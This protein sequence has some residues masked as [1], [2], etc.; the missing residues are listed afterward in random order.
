MRENVMVKRV[1]S[2]IVCLGLFATSLVAVQASKQ[3]EGASEPKTMSNAPAVLPI[4]RSLAAPAVGVSPRWSP[5]EAA[6]PQRPGSPRTPLIRGAADAKRAW[7]GAEHYGLTLHKVANREDRSLTIELR[8]AQDVVTVGIDAA[9]VVTVSRGGRAVRVRTPGSLARAQQLLAGS[10]AAFAARVMLADR[11]AVSDLKAP[12]MALL[13]A[14]AFVA[15]LVGDID[16]PRR[17]ATRFLEKHRGLY[18]PARMSTCFDAY[19]SES[20]SAWNDM[21]DCVDEANQDSSL[22]NRAY[23]R[24]ACNAIWLLRAESA[25]I[26]YLGCLGPKEIIPE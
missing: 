12:E 26:E 17:L 10:D 22:I 18:R 19:S 3:R 14:A 15:S 7:L 20:S 23:R 6:A 1:V 4:G 13:S 5:A 24:V 21:Q 8:F 9:A 2:G 25:W 11:E 16:A